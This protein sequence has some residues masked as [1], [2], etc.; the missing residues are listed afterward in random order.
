MNHR[1]CAA[2]VAVGFALF[3]PD[4][5]PGD[6]AAGVDPIERGRYLVMI[7]GCND[8]HTAGYAESAGEVPESDWLK[9]D[10]L[11]WQGPWGTTYAT[12]LRLRLA[13]MTEDSWVAFARNLRTRPPMPWFGLDKMTDEDLRAIYAY[14]RKLGPAGEPAPLYLPPGEQAATPVVRWEPPPAE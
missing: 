5:L 8:C 4:V 2:I 3:A 10:S 12:N 14:I 13:D 7:A 1:L 9:G 11:G 6:H